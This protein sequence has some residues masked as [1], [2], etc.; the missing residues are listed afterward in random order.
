MPSSCADPARH[1]PPDGAHPDNL[2]RG[3]QGASARP[4]V[5]S[6]VATRPWTQRLIQRAFY[7][8]SIPAFLDR[9]TDE[10]VGMLTQG[11]SFSIELTQRDAWLEEIRILRDALAG[12]RPEGGR[13]YFEF[14]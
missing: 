14:A 1:W 6:T 11:G 7:S 3:F 5:C 2:T 4:Q 10:V 12:Y 9:N 13:V 8:D